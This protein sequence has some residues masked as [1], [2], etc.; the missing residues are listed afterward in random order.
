MR[1]GNTCAMYKL[2]RLSSDLPLYL[3]K[4]SLLGLL[5][6]TE[7]AERIKST[8]IKFLLR[9]REYEERTEITGEKTV[10]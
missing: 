6:L 2:K 4:A 1:G 7:Y 10:M 3:F 8:G 9:A 5:L